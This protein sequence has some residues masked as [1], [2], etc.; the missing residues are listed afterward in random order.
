[1]A[2]KRKAKSEA[3][4]KLREKSS[5]ISSM[6]ANVGTPVTP[7]RR[8]VTLEMEPV[9]YPTPPKTLDQS[10]SIQKKREPIANKMV[11]KTSSVGESSEGLV[12]CKKETSAK[13]STSH[14]RKRPME[15]SEISESNDENSDVEFKSTKS[16]QNV[17]I[18]S[19]HP[20]VTQSSRKMKDLSNQTKALSFS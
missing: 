11:V 19:G 3:K 18:G 12:N 4:K 9:T 8:E 16:P 17:D 13:T 15:L 6:T 20:V 10:E 14:L 2:K 1:M 5:G 7:I